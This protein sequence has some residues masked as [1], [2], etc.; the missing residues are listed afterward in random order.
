MKYL[1]FFGSKVD[2]ALKEADVLRARRHIAFLKPCDVDAFVEKC[3]D[4][5]IMPDVPDDVATGIKCKYGKYNEVAEGS[6]E[7]VEPTKKKGK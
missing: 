5:V 1:I 3:D 4:I 2:E 7:P 6:P